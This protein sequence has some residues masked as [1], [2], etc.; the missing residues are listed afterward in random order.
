MGANEIKE[1]RRVR[2]VSM[3]IDEELLEQLRKMLEEGGQ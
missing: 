2:V 1:E 3:T